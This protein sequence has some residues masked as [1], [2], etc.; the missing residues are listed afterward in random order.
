M[1]NW[2]I[3]GP[4]LCEATLLLYDGSPFYPDGNILFDYMAAERGTLF[5]TSAKYID[6]LAKA[7]LDPAKSSHDLSALRH[8]HLDRLAPGARGLRLH[9]PARQ[10]GRL[11]VVDRRRHRH[12]RLLRRRQSRSPPCG[13]AR[14]KRACSPWRSRSGTTTASPCVGEKGEMVCTKPFP[15]M[16]VAFW[17]DPDGDALPGGLLREAFPGV[18]CHGDY[19]ELTEHDGIVIYGRSDATLQSGRRAHRHGR[20]LPPGRAAWRRCWRQSSSARTGRAT[21]ASSSSCA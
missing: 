14:F 18:W 17:N 11:P 3:S 21:S 13:A 5:G 12:H 1:W 19:V 9:I 10:R 7:E 15:S 20:D 4:R 2:L 6:A 8:G 16:P